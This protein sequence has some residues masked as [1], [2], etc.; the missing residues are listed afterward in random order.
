M[1]R[2]EPSRFSPY[3]A[4]RRLSRLA[5][6]TD[7]DIR[8]LQAAEA[9]ARYVSARS[10]LLH[11]GQEVTEVRMIVSGWA[12]T[13]RILADGRRQIIGLLLPGDLFGDC[14]QSRPL[15]NSSVVALTNAVVAVAPPATTSESLAEAYTLS[16][17]FADAY[18]M[19]QI[20]R[21]GR[22]SARERIIDLLLELHE[23]LRLTG[24]VTRD[25]FELP[26]TQE[27]VADA[28]GLT[29]VHLNRMLRD[30]RGHGDVEWRGGRLILRQPEALA[31]IAGRTPV[32][33]T[34][35]TF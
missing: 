4:T 18:L 20:V 15:A 24:L 11:E 5:P 31:L 3:A 1:T 13:V 12:A 17:A 23:R 14:R 26:L 6:L 2:A 9:A 32:Q 10:E 16:N 30:I 27:I 29:S 7:G 21:L 35:R 19:A 25:E 8:A 33:V 22:M 28:L 34:A